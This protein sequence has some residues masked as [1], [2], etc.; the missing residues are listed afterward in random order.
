MSQSVSGLQ[1]QI[2]ILQNYVEK[3]LLK[4]NPHKTKVLI[5]QKQNRKAAR[6]KHSF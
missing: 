3:W 1:K 2:D 5:F 4:I 6:E